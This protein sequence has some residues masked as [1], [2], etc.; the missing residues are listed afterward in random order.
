VQ[1]PVL[2]SVSDQG[3]KL[4]FSYLASEPARDIGDLSAALSDLGVADDSDKVVAA[5]AAG[6]HP[7]TKGPGCVEARAQPSGDHRA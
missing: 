4:S 3:Y 2:V 1:Q 7:G 5:L 6:I